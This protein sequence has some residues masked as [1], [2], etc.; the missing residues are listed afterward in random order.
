MKVGLIIPTRG[1][2]PDFLNFAYKQIS[3]QYRKPDE[4]ILVNDPPLSNK[5]DITYRYKIGIER[6]VKK[7]CDVML[8]WEDDDWYHPDYIRW[9]IDR[10]EYYKKPTLFG[11]DETYYYHIGIDKYLYMKH[12]QRASAFCTLVTPNILNDFIWPDF[13]YPFVDLKM[14]RSIN[15]KVAIPFGSII[16]A[17]GIKHGIGLTGGGGHRTNFK[18]SHHQGHDW[19]VKNIDQE[20]HDFYKKIIK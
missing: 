11:I 7:G 5:K 13:T 16:R 19:F 14:W 3:K 2:R 20:A 4:I 12:P 1:D 18:W 10:W 8:F 17:I 9:M 6:A 15:D